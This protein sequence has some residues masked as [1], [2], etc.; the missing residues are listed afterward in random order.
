[1]KLT[2]ELFNEVCEIWEGYLTHPFVKEL[3][4]GTLDH[5]KFKNYISPD[6]FSS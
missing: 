4:E 6:K 5:N 3:G 1:M 2:D